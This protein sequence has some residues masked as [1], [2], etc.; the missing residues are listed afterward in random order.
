MIEMLHSDSKI[1][2]AKNSVKIPDEF[3]D[4][5]TCNVIEDP[6]LLPGMVGYQSDN[7][8]DKSTIRKQLLIKQENPYTRA[9]LTI[10][11]FEEFNNRKD[12]QEKLNDFRTRFA[13]L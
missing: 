7:F 6:C 2:Q 12:I 3:M 13:N 1:D 5:I 10:D 9:P 8:F 11:E 4:P